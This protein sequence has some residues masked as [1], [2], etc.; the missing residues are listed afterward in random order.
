[1][2][3]NYYIHNCFQ[4]NYVMSFLSNAKLPKISLTKGYFGQFKGY[5]LCS[6]N[7]G[8]LFASEGGSWQRGFTIILRYGV[9]LI[10]SKL[11]FFLSLLGRPR[12]RIVFHPQP[13]SLP[14]LVREPGSW[15]SQSGLVAHQNAICNSIAAIP[16]DS[17]L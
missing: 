2:E 11:A 14:I 7:V 13:P 15:Q 17:A 3:C 10:D 5:I 16:P 4:V 1:M 12:I 8:G 6:G 9:K